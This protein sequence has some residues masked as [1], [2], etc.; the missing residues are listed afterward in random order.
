MAANTSF[1]L[2]AYAVQSLAMSPEPDRYEV[3]RFEVE[4]YGRSLFVVRV[5][6]NKVHSSLSRHETFSVGQKGATKTL[7]SSLLY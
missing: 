2:Q 3:V 5:M 7:T 6:Q 1:Q 4:D